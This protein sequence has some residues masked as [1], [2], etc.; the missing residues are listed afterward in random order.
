MSEVVVVAGVIVV[1]DEED[2]KE[3]I[4]L[5]YPTEFGEISLE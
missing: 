5:E 2:D 3:S 1:D 4:A